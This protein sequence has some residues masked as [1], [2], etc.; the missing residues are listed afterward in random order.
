M[1][2]EKLNRVIAMCV[3][4][5]VASEVRALLKGR[6][7]ESKAGIELIT[8]MRLWLKERGCPLPRWG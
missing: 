4:H 7:K 6:D 5:V 2:D 1:S 3:Q 8:A